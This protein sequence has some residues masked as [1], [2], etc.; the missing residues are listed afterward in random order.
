MVMPPPPAS[1]KIYHIV[2]T[3]RLSSIIA[4]GGLLCDTIIAPR[5]KTGTMIGI[6]DIKKRRLQSLISSRPGLRVGDCVPFYFCPRSIMLYII[7]CANHPNL[8]YRG[9]QEPIIHL[10]ADL[11]AAI[12]WA[13]AN[14]KRWAFTLSNAGSTYFEDR[15]DRDQLNEVDW[16]AVTATDWSA[17]AVKEGKQAEFLVEE[18]LPWALIERIGVYTTQIASRVALALPSGGHRPTVQVLGNWY[19]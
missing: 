7:H 12:A 3:D 5:Q 4:D 9:G 1:P 10:E 2:H 6:E 13:T 11:D 15:A 16:R 14:S 8:A 17:S 18:R 19:Y